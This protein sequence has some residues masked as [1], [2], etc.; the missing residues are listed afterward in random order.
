[1]TATADVNLKTISGE[2]RIIRAKKV[3]YITLT[4]QLSPIN[5]NQ[6]K[7][8]RKKIEFLENNY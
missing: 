3:S 4:V 1:M 7:N 6:K 2:P 8:W 5:K